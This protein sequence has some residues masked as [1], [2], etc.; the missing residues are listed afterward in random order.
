METRDVIAVAAVALLTIVAIVATGD[1]SWV[2]GIFGS[3]APVPSPSPESSPSPEISPIPQPTATPIL[4]PNV[5][6]TELVDPSCETC[7]NISRVSQN[8]I[9]NSQALGLNFTAQAIDAS[10]NEGLELISRYNI[11][12]VPTMLLSKEAGLSPAFMLAWEG[13][14]TVEAD[15]TLVLKEA[16]PPYIDLESGAIAGNVTLVNLLYEPCGACYDVA[17]VETGLRERYGVSVFQVVDYSY[18]SIEWKEIVEKYNITKVPAV[19]VSPELSAYPGVEEKWV[20]A[21][22]TK[23]QDGWFVFR[24]MDVPEAVYYDLLLNS[25]VQKIY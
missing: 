10:S 4:L 15:G 18:D 17:L 8:F 22:G 6:I 20:G 11:T 5:K 19:L 9:A 3:P 2:A 23:E 21:L 14:G 13:S 25:T 24:S 12:K 1:P 16:Y 7:F